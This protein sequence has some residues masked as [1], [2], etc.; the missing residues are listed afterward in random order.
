MTNNEIKD[1]TASIKD[2]AFKLN[3]TNEHRAEGEDVDEEV[4]D[5][6]AEYDYQTENVDIE[7]TAE[8]DT[9]FAEAIN[10][11]ESEAN[12]LEA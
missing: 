3:L 10:Y 4:Q 8:I 1:L 6:F 2:L 9:D 12:C 5:I 11:Y 7:A